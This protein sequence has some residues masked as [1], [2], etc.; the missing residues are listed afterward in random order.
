M[1][2]P[3]DSTI[4]DHHLDNYQGSTSNVR[5]KTLIDKDF[6]RTFEKGSLLLSRF[7]QIN[8]KRMRKKA[9]KDGMTVIQKEA[10]NQSGEPSK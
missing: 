1:G 6:E 4:G 5:R 3:T 7:Q 8:L 9:F 2:V 10:R